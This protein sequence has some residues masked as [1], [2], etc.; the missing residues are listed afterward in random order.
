MQ[1]KPVHFECC[2]PVLRVEDMAASLRFYVDVLGFAAAEWTTDEFGYISR[3]GAGVYLSRGDQGRGGAWIWVGVDDVRTL[4]KQ[5]K[6]RGAKIIMAPTN[7][8]WAL[9]MQVEDPDGNV[10]RIGS[11]PETTEGEV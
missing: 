10:L 8:P 2:N 6:A 9:E 1:E 7:F 3:D 5:Y 11:E 4:Y